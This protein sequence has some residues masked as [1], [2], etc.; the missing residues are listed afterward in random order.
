[1]IG[2]F[3]PFSLL[4]MY[5][6]F[7]NWSYAFYISDSKGQLIPNDGNFSIRSADLAHRYY[8]ICDSANVP[9]GYQK[10]SELELHKVGQIMMRTILSTAPI[11][12]RWDTLQLHRVC[13]YLEDVSILVHNIIMYEAATDIR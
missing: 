3:H 6:S 10:E 8:A 12:L 9:T 4:P 13:Y 7:P 2:E 11:A 1:M 5:D